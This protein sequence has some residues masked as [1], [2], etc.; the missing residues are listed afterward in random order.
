MEQHCVLQK[1]FATQMVNLCHLSYGQSRVV[2]T[3]KG[4]TEWLDTRKGV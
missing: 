2:K 1:S 4:I 3:A